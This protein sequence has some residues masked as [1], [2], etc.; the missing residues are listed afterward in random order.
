VGAEVYGVA[1]DAYVNSLRTT[2]PDARAGAALAEIRLRW[3]DS[4]SQM[5][6]AGPRM[7]QELLWQSAMQ[8]RRLAAN[9]V[10]AWVEFNANVMRTTI[11][12]AQRA[13]ACSPKGSQR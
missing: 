8:Q 6:L 13:F 4:I 10:Q 3:M 1:R 2:V 5:A 9:A 11:D 7:S 12:I